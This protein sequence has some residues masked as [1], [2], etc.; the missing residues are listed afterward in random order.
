LPP[1]LPGGRFHYE[2]EKVLQHDGESVIVRYPEY[3]L[4]DIGAIRY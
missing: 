4:P 2:A 1:L 3:L